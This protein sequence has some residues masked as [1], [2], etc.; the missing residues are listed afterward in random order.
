MKNSQNGFSV[1]GIFAIILVIGIVFYAGW[2]VSKSSDDTVAKRTSGIAK[3]A[4]VA[5]EIFTPFLVH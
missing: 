3:T 1:V 2:V 4:D 5:E